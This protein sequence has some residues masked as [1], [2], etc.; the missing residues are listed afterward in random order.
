ML[1]VL[2][3]ALLAAVI[4]VVYPNDFALQ[5]H[6]SGYICQNS[7][8]GGHRHVDVVRVA[9]DLRLLIGVLTLPD[10]YERRNLLR[11]VY[12][13]QQPNLTA[14]R[15]DVRFFFCRLASEEQRV[16]VALEAMRYGDVV[17]LDC[18]ENMDRGKTDAYFSSVAALFGDAA[19]DFVMK[20]DD[21]TFFRLPQLADSLRRAPREDLYYGCRWIVA[22]AD[23]I[24]NR[25]VG[26]EDRTL[27]R[28]FGLAGKA[29]NWVDA[30]PAMYDFPQ[31]RDA[32]AHELVPDTIAVHKL[33][34][35]ERW[36][37]TLKYFNFTAGLQ[38]SKLYRN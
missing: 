10:L 7:A 20:A 29:K 19:Y 36:Y 3:L 18:Q 25:T 31:I 16:L 1:F 24:R 2:P 38:P 6:V 8:G 9:P 35:N 5:S 34:T 28:W 14:A 22:A 32:C 30:K 13:L 26:P 21:D 12:A 27:R 37:T 4:L 33:K 17:E 15:I 23:Q 11:T